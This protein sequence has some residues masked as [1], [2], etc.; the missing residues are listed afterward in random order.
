MTEQPTEQPTPVERP[1]LPDPKESASSS[2]FSAYDQE[3][4]RF[5]GGVHDTKGK[6]RDAAKARGASKIEVRAV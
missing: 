3:R 2:R 1:Q 5:V 6:A 4:L